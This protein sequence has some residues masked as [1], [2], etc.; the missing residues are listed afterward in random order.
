[1]E[2]ASQSELLWAYAITRDEYAKRL[3]EKSL[4]K[5]EDLEFIRDRIFELINRGE[6]H[7]YDPKEEQRLQ[8]VV[9][10]YL[11]PEADYI[12]LTDIAKRFDSKNPSYV[13]QSWLRSRNTIAF[14]GQWER[15]NNPNFDEQ[16]FQQL[17][18][19]VRSPSYTLTPVR[20][21]ERVNAVGIISRRGK[22]GGT[23]A[24]HFI[25]CDFEMWND[26][27]FRYNIF[28]QICSAAT[29]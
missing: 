10:K 1:M 13:I 16:A 7:I 2:R 8:A 6:A 9:E 22:N 3:S 27:A 15:E 26:V 5:T 23:T 18:V 4:L 21:I 20:W 29:N 25:A 12:S 28:K 14:L 11:Y 19:D 17:L 24:H